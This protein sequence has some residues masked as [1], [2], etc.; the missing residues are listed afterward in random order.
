[1]SLAI[2][3][4]HTGS[5][6]V[7]DLSG[8]V[9]A[10]AGANQLRDAIRALGDEGCGSILL[11]FQDVAFLDSAGLGAMVVASDQLRAR[12]GR[13]CIVNAHGPVQHVLQIT[14]LDRVFPHFADEAAALAGQA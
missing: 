6:V 2:S 1:M 8:R 5:A 14:R 3:T 11:N 7:L 4:R 13:L 10:G 9:T 12:G